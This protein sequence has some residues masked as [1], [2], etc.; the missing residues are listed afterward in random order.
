MGNFLGGGMC[1]GGGAGFS[2]A[3]QA[4]CEN[5]E[6]ACQTQ[7]LRGG[8]TNKKSGKEARFFIEKCNRNPW[9]VVFETLSPERVCVCVCVCEYDPSFSG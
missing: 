3:C 5:N 8:S 7:R 2:R 1:G 4:T 6:Q 9:K